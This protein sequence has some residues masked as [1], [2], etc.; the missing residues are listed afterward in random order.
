MAKGIEFYRDYIKI[1][2]LKNSN[3]TQQFTDR[4][5]KLFDT[6]NRKHPKEGIKMKSKDFKVHNVFIINTYY[7]VT[8]ISDLIIEFLIYK[9]RF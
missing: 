8:Y 2:S 1:D 6:F 7:D 5:N 3:E 9:T 4:F